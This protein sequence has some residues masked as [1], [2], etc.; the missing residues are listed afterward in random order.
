[1]NKKC[2]GE[3]KSIEKDGLP[4]K[5][6]DKYLVCVSTSIEMVKAPIIGFELAYLNEYEK[7][8]DHWDHIEMTSVTHYAEIKGPN[9]N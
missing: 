9:D 7:W 6:N 1:M 4:K 5:R 3:W 8:E 2:C